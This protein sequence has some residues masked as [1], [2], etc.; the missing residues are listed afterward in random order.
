MK[1][2]SRQKL[3][4]I[5]TSVVLAVV[6]AIVCYHLLDSKQSQRKVVQREVELVAQKRDAANR[7]M[8]AISDAH[9][10]SALG[11]KDRAG[12][13]QN[14]S[15]LDVGITAANEVRDS[16]D[17]AKAKLD[18]ELTQQGVPPADRESVTAKLSD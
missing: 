7:A 11:L 8:K 6:I 5:L 3:A 16:A 4:L 10:I 2:S 12:L 18:G 1:F 17:A 15:L 13:D 9:A 14:L